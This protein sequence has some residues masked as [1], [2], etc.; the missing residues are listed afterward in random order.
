MLKPLDD[1]IIVKL[2][3]HEDK[4]K[5]GLIIT[6]SLQDEI[7]YATVIEIGPETDKIKPKLNK[8]QKVIIKNNVGT[9]IKYEGDDLI[10]VKQS[11]I[12][13]VIE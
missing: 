5:S 1:R 11:D 9:K 6:G 2:Q 10:I 13:A 12:L 4:T 7:Q 3:E 8:G